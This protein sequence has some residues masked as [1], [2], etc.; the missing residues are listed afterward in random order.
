M[1]C[2][3]QLFLYNLL[4]K[5]SVRKRVAERDHLSSKSVIQPVEL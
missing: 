4:L 2:V 1:K 5:V 3:E